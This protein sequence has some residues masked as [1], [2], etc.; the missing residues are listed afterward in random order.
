MVRV[1]ANQVVT[2]ENIYNRNLTAELDADKIY[3]ELSK[4]F[5]DSNDVSM[6]FGEVAIYSPHF[7]KDLGSAWVA[8][9][10]DLEAVG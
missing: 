10:D 5:A 1:K 4:T 6:E 2:V 7:R 8:M 9:A 3:F